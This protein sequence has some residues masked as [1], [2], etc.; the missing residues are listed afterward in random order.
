MFVQ[1][2]SRKRFVNS[3]IEC[4]RRRQLCQIPRILYLGAIAFC[5][6]RREPKILR[7]EMKKL[8]VMEY[9][10]L[11][12]RL[13]NLGCFLSRAMLGFAIFSG[14]CLYGQ[15]AAEPA[16]PG[17]VVAELQ[18]G[19][20]KVRPVVQGN[21]TK[22][23]MDEVGRLGKVEPKKIKLGEREILVDES[24]FYSGRY[25]SPL[26]YARALD[27]AEKH[28]FAPTKGAKV[29]D[30]GYGSIG[31]LRMFAQMGLN[32][33]GVD[34]EPLLPVM[35]DG[36]S[37]PLGEGSVQLLNG[38]FPA[39]EKLVEAA[40]EG[41][42]LF[43][44]KNTL[45]RGYIHPSREPAS[46][47]HIIQLG[48]TD[49]KYL[50]RVASMLKPGGLFVIYNFCPPKAAMDKPYIPWAEGESPFTRE[51]LV[52]AGFEV[53]EYDVVDDKEARDLGHRLGWD[54][55]GGMKLET[56][57]FAWYTVARKK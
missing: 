25:G 14:S 7:R 40:G 55:P 53:L 21:W 10:A 29:F 39:E 24:L 41:Y 27:L 4:C 11:G 32:A 31:H 33:T 13:E 20:E 23:W 22:S 3:R 6:V 8:A 17:S 36:C 52:N 57:L 37:G 1:L 46:P 43:L 12:L 15:E 30:F 47:R 28:G 5:Y 19:I 2:S 38:R 54:A 42:D 26:T 56:D 49:G 48:V 35:Y 34:V 16:V 18:Q 9:F 44:S 51:E 50:E 45:K